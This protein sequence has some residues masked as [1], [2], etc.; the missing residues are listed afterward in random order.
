MSRVSRRASASA[1]RIQP[2]LN[3]ALIDR[4][5]A[6][7]RPR[8]EEPGEEA[9]RRDRRGCQCENATSASSGIS[10]PA[11]SRASRTAARRAARSSSAASPTASPDS[12]RPPGPGPG[13][14]RELRFDAASV[15]RGHAN[16]RGRRSAWRPA[17]P[18]WLR[19]PA[20]RAH[21]A[22]LFSR[23]LSRPSLPPPARESAHIRQGWRSIID[24][25]LGWDSN[26]APGADPRERSSRSGLRCVSESNRTHAPRNLATAREFS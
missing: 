14:K 3:L 4:N 5:V 19:H 11:S 21:S 2:H 10:R 7:R 25:Q 22:T 17:S 13:N 15:S 1:G 20:R 9:F 8:D 6:A 12:T 24:L 23:D 16:H 18:R 26:H